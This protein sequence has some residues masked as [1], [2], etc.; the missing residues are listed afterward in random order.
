MSLTKNQV[1]FAIDKLL[2]NSSAKH[3][4]SEI[5]FNSYPPDNRI[6]VVYTLHRYLERTNTIRGDIKELLITTTKPAKPAS[7]DTLRRWT[8]T[9]LT[10]AGID[11]NMF[12]PY[13]T[14]SAAVSKAAQSIKVKDIVKAIGWQSEKMF[15]KHYNKK[16]INKG[17]FSDAITKG[18]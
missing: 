15:V 13:S 2:K 7:T 10:E 12:K 11:M 3:H 9:T 4:L 5:T 6:C 1:S 18:K 16:L 14:R 8:K 17:Y